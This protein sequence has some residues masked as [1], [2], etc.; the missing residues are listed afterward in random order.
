MPHNFD[1]KL[2]L[3]SAGAPLA[4]GP[5]DPH[6]EKMF[7][8]WVWV[9]QDDTDAAARGSMDWG[10]NPVSPEWNCTTELWGDSPPFST[11]ATAKCM[12]VA[13]VKRGND[14]VFYGW[15]DDAEIV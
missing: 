7:R 6:S 15:W 5:V 3:D 9:T 13:L 1:E 11:G 8:I 12:A 14:R 2:N 10:D 4:K